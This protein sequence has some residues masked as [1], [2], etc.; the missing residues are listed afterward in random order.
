MRRVI[1]FVLAVMLAVGAAGCRMPRLW[2]FG[3]RRQAPTD[4]PPPPQPAEKGAIGLPKPLEQRFKTETID[5]LADEISR[6]RNGLQLTIRTNKTRYTTEEPIILDVRVE[7]RSGMTNDERDKERDI[8]VYFEPF[9]KVKGGRSHEWL[10]KF[11]VRSE[12]DQRAVYRSQEFTVPESERGDYYHFVTLP[13]R[14][15]VGRRF[16]FPPAKVRNWLKQGRY[17]IIASYEV[18][19]DFPYVIINRQF[20]AEQVK[21][22]G[23]KLAY[24]RVWTGR[25]YSNRAVI[26]IRPKRRRWWWP[27]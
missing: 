15:Y 16:V 25:L 6:P 13:P 23:S 17:S 24:A 2:P 27:F 18:S 20:S 5:D 3:G 4:L 22:L 7:N 21:I 9:A 19:K 8:P 12:E 10:F 1:P 11:H 26:E 14:A